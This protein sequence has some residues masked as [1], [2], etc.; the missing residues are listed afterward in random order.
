MKSNSKEASSL[1]RLPPTL[2]SATDMHTKASLPA[3]ILR[4]EEVVDL[5]VPVSLR[6]KRPWVGKLAP[7]TAD[8]T[9]SALLPVTVGTGTAVSGLASVVSR[10][11]PRKQ[12]PEHNR[13]VYPKHDT[14]VVAVVP[15]SVA[16]SSNGPPIAS[17]TPPARLVTAV[18]SIPSVAQPVAA[19]MAVS[20]K[21]PLLET[22]QPGGSHLH[23]DVD[24][25]ST[26]RAQCDLAV[27]NVML[28]AVR[29]ELGTSGRDSGGSQAN[30]TDERKPGPPAGP[31]TF[32]G[33]LSEVQESLSHIGSRVAGVDPVLAEMLGKLSQA[34]GVA[35]DHALNVAART[36]EEI[37]LLSR[38]N[39]LLVQQL[40]DAQ[41]AEMAA[42]AA[43]LHGSRG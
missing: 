27:P 14:A 43:R 22:A 36:H 17:L 5:G 16:P 18:P 38:N 6:P 2:T 40:I 12:P 20:P 29:A 23:G 37:E 28:G 15:T 42:T 7:P 26:C 41:A 39:A 1:L 34:V 30:P 21:G 24:H 8:T 13:T 33:L 32:A 31:S 35:T 4:L 11:D 19:V 3:L 25:L 10:R 9:P